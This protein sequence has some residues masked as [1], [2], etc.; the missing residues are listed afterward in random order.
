MVE[1]V[2]VVVGPTRVAVHRLGCRT[3]PGVL[4]YRDDLRLRAILLSCLSHL[5]FFFLPVRLVH[6]EIDE[7]NGYNFTAIGTAR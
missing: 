6:Q 2:V 3:P 7:T 5:F 1:R 4:L